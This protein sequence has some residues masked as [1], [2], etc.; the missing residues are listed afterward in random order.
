MTPE[1]LET[2]VR[3]HLDTLVPS[4][5]STILVAEAR[6]EAIVGYCNVHWLHSLFMPGPEGYVS[7]LFVLPECRGRGI[8]SAL[9]GRIV[10]EAEERGAYRLT[11]LNGKHRESY[12]LGFYT[13][14]GWEERER[15]ANFVFWVGRH[16][17][18]T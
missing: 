7:E 12:T 13:K 15:M 10:T 6:D 18:M 5:A 9:L 4:P 2:N 1:Q 11:L 3:L 17:S 14:Q 16:G 8:G